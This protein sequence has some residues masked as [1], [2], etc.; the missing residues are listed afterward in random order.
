MLHAVEV[1]P[2]F[3]HALVIL[4]FE[5]CLCV[6]IPTLDVDRYQFGKKEG[7]DAFVLILGFH[8]HKQEIN[9]IGFSLDSL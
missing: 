6:T 9:T 5:I 8:C 3:L 7:V 2:L 4:K 1:F